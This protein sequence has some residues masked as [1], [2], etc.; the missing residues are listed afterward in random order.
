MIKYI[1]KIS[2]YISILILSFANAY[3]DSHNTL[4]ILEALQQDI[5]TL[6]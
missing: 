2:I 1:S 6:E 5:K 4:Q 3:S